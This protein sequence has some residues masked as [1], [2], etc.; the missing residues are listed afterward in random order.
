[1]SLLLTIYHLPLELN[2]VV[3]LKKL[4][5]VNYRN[6]E[7]FEGNFDHLKTIIIGQNA[8]GKTNILEAINILAT[9][10]SDR[11]EKDNDLVFWNKEHALIFATIQTNTG[12]GRDQS[13]LEIAL[14]IN[15]SGRRKLK[16]NDVTKKAPQA[17]LLGNF[18]AVMFSCDDLYLIKGSP[19]VRRNWLDSVIFQLDSK[20]HRIMQDYQKSVTQKNALLKSAKE[21]GIPRKALK[22]QLEIWNEQII[23]S[24]S[25]IINTRLHFIEEIKPIAKDFQSNISRHIENLDLIYKCTIQIADSVIA[26]SVSNDKEAL[27]L[28]FKQSL[29]KSF[30][31]ELGRGQSVI[32]PHRDDLIFLINEKEA[33]SFASQGQQRSIVLAIKLA[34][35]KIIEKRKNEIPVLL[36]DD[37]FAELDESRQDFLLHNLPE[38]IQTFLTTTHISNIQK[39]FL[40]G[41]QILEIKNGQV[42]ENAGRRI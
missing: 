25:E 5:L 35:L 28:L 38:N 2:T 15:P 23:N 16:I 37:V 10:Q 34:E 42:I 20:Y 6:Y 30:E 39:E 22:E 26:R 40:K 21:T 41:A 18:F 12:I 11:A 24:G 3:Y 33:K 27:Q 13:L 8:Q 4:K 9:A 31:E 14:Q 32:G 7:S 17:D 29:E 1:M 36:L 19:S